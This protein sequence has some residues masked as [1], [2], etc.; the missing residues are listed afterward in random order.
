LAALFAIG[1]AST[2]LAEKRVALIVANADYKG[3]ALQNPTFDADLVATSL[4]NIGFVVKVVK[5]RGPRNVRCRRD[6]LR[7]R[8]AGR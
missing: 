5:K 4:Q 6:R 7:R 3:A 2:A 8:R 1:F